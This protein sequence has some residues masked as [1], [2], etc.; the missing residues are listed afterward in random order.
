MISSNRK[1]QI[2]N[3]V[4]KDVGDIPFLP[5]MVDGRSWFRT[6]EQTVFLKS[7]TAGYLISSDKKAFG[8]RIAKEWLKTWPESERLFGRPS[9]ENLPLTD[10]EKERR[11][12]ILNDAVGVRREVSVESSCCWAYMFT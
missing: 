11:R 10:E 3:C 9:P 5:T 2:Y 8:G 1:G 6:Q 7:V 4:T 12:L